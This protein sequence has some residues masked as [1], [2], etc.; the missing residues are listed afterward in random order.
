MPV[1][2]VATDSDGDPLSYTIVTRPAHGTLN[3]NPPDMVYTPDENYNGSDSFSFKV[4]DGTND[5]NVTNVSITIQSV[6]DAPVAVAGKSVFMDED[7]PTTITLEA[8]DPDGDPLTYKIERAPLYG[9]L[10]GT[11]P[12]VTYTPKKDFNFLD[13]FTFSASDGK[14]KSNIGTISITVNSV[15]DPPIANND[16]AETFEDAPIEKIDVLVNDTDVDKD[17]LTVKE[18]TQASHGKVEINSD[19]TTIKYTPEH[20]YN[21]LDTFTY[22]VKDP[23]GL[24]STAK[25]EVKIIPLN[26]PPEITSKPVTTAMLDVPYVYDVNAIDPD[27]GDK[28]SYSLISKPEGMTIEKDTGIIN[29]LPDDLLAA[30]NDVT[31]KVTDNNDIPASATQTFSIK[32]IPTPSKIATLTVTSGYDKYG[33]NAFTS[34]KGAGVVMTSDNNYLEIKPGFSVAF[35]FSD[36][37]LPPNSTIKSLVIYVEHHE[38]ENYPAGREKWSI[39]ENW[40]DKP[41]VWFTIDAPIQGGKTDDSMDSWDA[42]SVVNTPDKMNKLQLQIMNNDSSRSIFIDYVYA[43]AQWDWPEEPGLVEYELKPVR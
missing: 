15:N 8:N 18:V 2:L 6:E 26:D 4:S 41:E 40:P 14:N 11:G 25:V 7:T 5:S 33:K 42:A 36:V 13:S 39:G 20:N 43:I 27:G 37:T 29:W 31:V 21:G 10:T 24:T 35:D 23:G 32:V 17:P 22:T 3:Q 19:N 30:P 1:T 9:T 12:Q 16:K 34:D 38:Q 28:L